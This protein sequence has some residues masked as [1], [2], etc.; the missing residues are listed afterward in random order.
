MS[1]RTIYIDSSVVGG[2]FDTEWQDATRELWRQWELGRWRMITSVVTVAEMLNAPAQ[3]RE[4]FESTFDADSVLQATDEMDALAEL[5]LKARVV[6][7]RYSDDARHVAA[8]VAGGCLILVTWNFRHLA[9]VNREA[10][11]NAVNL[12]HGYPAVR[13]V[14]P[15]EVIYE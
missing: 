14:S 4:L 12:L 11:F 2:Y 1:I 6:P 8:C 3:V 9:N 13:M 15:L 7:T 5:Y 10:G